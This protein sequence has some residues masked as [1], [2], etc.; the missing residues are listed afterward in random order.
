M[1]D[2]ET[3]KSIEDL[4]RLK[5]EGIIT[6]AEFERSKEK[7]LFGPKPAAARP[8]LGSVLPPAP[9]GLPDEADHV[10]WITL[11]LKRYADFQGRSTRKEFWMFQI[12]YLGL[13]AVGA[14]AV[15]DTDRWGD[16]GAFGTL[17]FGLVLLAALGLLVPTLAVEV[18]RL[19]DQDRSG[20]LVL[21]N[22][23]PYVGWLVVYILMLIE[24]T[25]GEN[26]FG[27]DPRQS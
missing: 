27:P 1:I 25:R 24:G 2:Q 15:S 14:L 9:T 4:H 12:I 5:N 6:E 23:I 17:T 22:L 8:I 10:G 16:L 20:W 7:L 13:G 21:L 11:P 26:R 18:R 3:L 19:H